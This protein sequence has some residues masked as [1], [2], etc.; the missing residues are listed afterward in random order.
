M[1]EKMALISSGG[2]EISQFIAMINDISDRINLLSLNAA[3]EAA[4]AGDHGR[5]FAVVADE[6]GKL[7]VATSENSKQIAQQVSRIIV[8][9]EEGS[10]IVGAT[11]GSTERIFSMV[12]DIR[13][14]MDSVGSLLQKQVAALDI[15]MKQTGLVDTLS[16]RIAS[17]TEEQNRTMEDTLKT[18]ERL[19]KMAQEVSA[20]NQRIVQSITTINDKSVELLSLIKDAD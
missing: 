19:S 11:R 9:I 14:G 1:F 2:R 5:G 8:D 7:A 17:A 10:A 15:V 4:R 6:I 18:V 12:K 16:E 20:S 13:E 3:I